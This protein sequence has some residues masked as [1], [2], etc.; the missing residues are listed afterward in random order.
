[1]NKLSLVLPVY[2]EAK[3]IKQLILDWENEFKKL[4]IDYEIIICE[5]G[6]TDGTKEIL[7]EIF[8]NNNKII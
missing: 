2:N 8:Q 1:M 3:I 4:K 6:S 7:T 5:D